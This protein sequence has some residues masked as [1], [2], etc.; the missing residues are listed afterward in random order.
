[1]GAHGRIVLCRQ[2]LGDL[3]RDKLHDWERKIKN[4]R[5]DMVRTSMGTDDVNIAR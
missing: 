1:M 2:L 5:Q 3:W 4:H